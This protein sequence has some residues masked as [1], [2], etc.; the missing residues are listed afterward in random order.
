[1]RGTFA[2]II[3][4]RLAAPKGWTQHLPD[5]RVMTILMAQQYQGRACRWS[6]SRNQY[7]TGG[8]RRLGGQERA[9]AG[10]K[11]VTPPKLER[12]HRS[13]LVECLTVTAG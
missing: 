2:N 4:N 12:I 3:R 11:A 13:N 1:M 9:S 5:R 10:V 6:C 8:G 7:G